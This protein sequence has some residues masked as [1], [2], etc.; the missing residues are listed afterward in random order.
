MEYQ[1][2][3]SYIDGLQRALERLPAQARIAFAAWCT[4][5]FFSG[6]VRDFLAANGGP[7]KFAAVEDAREYFWDCASGG[8][9]SHEQVNRPREACESLDWSEEQ[10]INYDV[11]TEQ[12]ALD[13]LSSLYRGLEVCETGSA[14]GATGCAE[15]VLERLDWLLSG[16]VPG[17]AYCD[18]HFADPTMSA[19]VERQAKMLALLEN[20]LHLSKAER[21]LFRE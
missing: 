7:Q 8:D 16:K 6:G 4:D 12:C 1:R 18:E 11:I 19:E 9:V 17:D 3:P 10:V 20:Q 2:F 15:T 5:S 13:A 21:R 14:L